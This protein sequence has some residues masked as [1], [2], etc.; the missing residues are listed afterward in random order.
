MAR[1]GQPDLSDCT[2]DKLLILG[3]AQPRGS[4]SPAPTGVGEH[5][6][7]GALLWFPRLL[8]LAQDL[9]V[10]VTFAEEE[11]QLISLTIPVALAEP[12]PS[13]Y[14]HALIWPFSKI[15]SAPFYYFVACLRLLF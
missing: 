9:C 10:C 5:R 12:P 11:F 14:L 3:P 4:P 2:W 8:A 7:L 6:P 13:I 1:R 15:F